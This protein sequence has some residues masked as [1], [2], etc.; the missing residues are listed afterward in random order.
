[1]ER[2]TLHVMDDKQ[3]IAMTETRTL[4]TASNDQ[5][6]RQLI[7]YELGNHLCSACLELDACAQIISYEEYSPYGSSTYQA[8][9]NQTDSPKRYRYTGKERDEESGIYYHGAR[10]YAPWLGRWTLPDP[11]GLVDGPNLY[12][13]SR[14]CPVVVTD[15]LGTAPPDPRNY[16]SFEAF[17]ADAPSPYSMEY[18]QQLWQESHPSPPQS[19]ADGSTEIPVE[20][21]V[22]EA[23]R[24]QLA[25][26]GVY[27]MPDNSASIGTPVHLI[28]LPI[29]SAR[30]FAHGVPN[31]T[32]SESIWDRTVAPAPARGSLPLGRHGLGCASLG[33]VDGSIPPRYEGKL[34]RGKQNRMQPLRVAAYST[35]VTGFS[36]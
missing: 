21:S 23:D 27:I 4:D 30:L 3:R 9:R 18:L 36:T 17:S 14:N 35:A 33:Q 1:M 22:S 13:Y 24:S 20:G 5:A 34:C 7:R 11:A 12:R 29:L 32:G 10:Y 28:V 16:E 8:V 31:L 15:P 2:D 6:P 25:S 19:A 26:G